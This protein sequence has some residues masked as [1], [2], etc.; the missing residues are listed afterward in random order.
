METADQQLSRGIQDLEGWLPALTR[1]LSGA[2]TPLE[3]AR[4]IAE[5]AQ[6]LVGWD[7]LIITYYDPGLQMTYPL[8]VMDLDDDDCIREYEEQ[9]GSNNPAGPLIRRV[10][11][12]GPL[13]L[14]EE[15]LA[16]GF[17]PF[18]NRHR[19]ISKSMILVPI[20]EG[21]HN[22]VGMLALH[23]YQEGAYRQE[24]IGLV[25]MLA[26]LCCAAV[27][28]IRAKEAVLK[29]EAIFRLAV[30]QTGAVPYIRRMGGRAFEYLGPGLVEMTGCEKALLQDATGWDLIIREVVSVQGGA[31]LLN[32]PLAESAVCNASTWRAD[33]RIQTPSGEERWLTDSASV[34]RD[35]QGRTIAVVGVLVD[36]TERMRSTRNEAML[37]TMMKQLSGVNS[38][39]EA[40]RILATS[41]ANLV[42][43]DA[44]FFTVFD[45]ANDCCHTVYNVDTISGIKREVPPLLDMPRRPTPMLRAIL[46]AGP[47]RILRHADQRPPRTLLWGSGKQCLSLLYIPVSAEGGDQ[48]LGV[49]SLQSYE[50]KAYSEQDL[51][52]VVRLI[53]MASLALQ[54]V[55]T[56]EKFQRL[57]ERSRQFL[58]LVQRLNEVRSPEKAG[59]IIADVASDLL[60]WDSCFIVVHSAE[61]QRLMDVVAYDT[62]DGERRM[63]GMPVISTNPRGYC[64]AALEQGSLLVLRTEEEVSLAQSS[65]NYSPF[66]DA[67]RPSRSLMFA[68]ARIG[69]ETVG[70]ISVQSYSPNAYTRAELDTLQELADY[71]AGALVRI[72]VQQALDEENHFITRI[73]LL[74]QQLA[75]ADTIASAGDMILRTARELIGWDVCY[76]MAY[77]QATDEVEP[78][79]VLETVEGQERVV[80]PGG[81]GGKPKGY[82]RKVLQEKQILV[83]DVE[84]LGRDEPR[85]RFGNDKCASRSLMYSILEVGDEVVGIISLQSYK[86]GFYTKEKLSFMVR[87]ADRC[88]GAFARIRAHE[89]L[90]IS[91]ERYAI[92]VR[93]ANDGIWDWD[94]QR[95]SLFLSDRFRA[96]SGLPMQDEA[97]MDDLL[98]R[99]HPDDRLS[100]DSMLETL[101]AGHADLLRREL[102]FATATP[103]EWR[104]TLCRGAVVRDNDGVAL[105]I[106]GSLS[107]ITD[108]RLAEQKLQHAAFYDPLTGLPNRA[109]FLDRLEHCLG[110]ARRSTHLKFA[111]LFLDLDRFK[112]VNDSLGHPVGDELLRQIGRRLTGV[113]RDTDTIARLGGDEF[114][115]LLED[116]ADEDMAV[117]VA[118]RIIDSFSEPFAV[119]DHDVYTATS[120]GIA[121]ASNRSRTVDEIIRDADTALYRAKELGRGRWVV[122]DVQM[123]ER[124]E[125]M[126]RT[127]AGLR[128]ALAN[129]Q[130]LLHYQPIYNLRTNEV[131][132]FEALVRWRRKGEVVM[133]SA[134]IEV[135]EET[136]LILP[137]GE[138]VLAEACRQ[139]AL[140]KEENLLWGGRF[141]SV[142]VSPKRFASAAVSHRLL[143][144]VRASGLESGLVHLEITESAVLGDPGAAEEIL[145]QWHGA[146]VQI[147]LDDF[148][149]GFSSLTHLARLPVDCLKIDRSFVGGMIDKAESRHVVEGILSLAEIMHLSVVAEGIET[150]EQLELLRSLSCE[151]GQGFLL[152]VPLDAGGATEL[153][154]RQ[155]ME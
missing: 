21:E 94:L 45:P 127:E 53:G 81:I 3:A 149:T 132:G 113:L 107:D 14:G 46:T 36:T 153:L 126:V 106:A 70:I 104:W 101:R 38:L 5:G 66:G 25:S 147:S 19:P 145:R 1:R 40:A 51:S 131:V 98:S 99:L 103:G 125:A 69:G 62:V 141:V 44:C 31:A 24:Q 114:T 154:R 54:R 83:T 34:Q 148:G 102:R 123:H 80:D 37:R 17:Q 120:I 13:L 67:G 95:K 58:S 82:A 63:I 35:G 71:C 8:L 28:R 143:D 33:Y 93:G 73:G 92:S 139:L 118:E 152:S 11:Q 155:K 119:L 88:A 50:P 26:D 61:N 135:A 89:R 32:E 110:R 20:M 16:G 115:I 72:R 117:R 74:S 150:Q 41:A 60:G 146:G 29:D 97:T 6:E 52:R 56:A 48:P 43:W 23:R 128:H 76:L 134:F 151:L 75:H 42:P 18:G 39:Y 142:N 124:V 49:F 22:A 65:G 133:P 2:R 77:D 100:L 9:Q 136:G 109:L 78:L 64:K 7:A 27:H 68:P 122:F 111:V 96:I 47:Q 84:M 129:S 144:V 59:R 86:P 90:R 12:E 87:L 137:L 138:W 79:Y 105:R 130:F 15:A 91:E 55:W 116:L 112:L 30:T 57:E 85:I 121:I 4:L 140:W 108:Q 10:I